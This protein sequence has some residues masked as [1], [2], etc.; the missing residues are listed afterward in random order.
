MP[1]RCLLLRQLG[2]GNTVT[3]NKGFSPGKRTSTSA[4]SVGLWRSTPKQR[5]RRSARIAFPS[6]GKSF[7][8][9]SRPKGHAPLATWTSCFPYSKTK[10]QQKKSCRA[11]VDARLLTSFE[12]TAGEEE[13]KGQH[14]VEIIHESLLKAWP[15][16]VRW[17]TQDEEGAQLRDELR[18][19][20]QLW[21]QHGR[22]ADR[23]W[24]GTP[25]KEFQLWRERY[26]GGLTNTEQDF[27][28]A[29]VQQA[30]RRRKRKRFAIA[31]TIGA[32]V[33]VVALVSAFLATE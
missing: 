29:M 13:E 12:V 6:Y 17:Q 30:E 23:L 32:L 11:L 9:W 24:T 31:A 7:A 28:Q 2:C 10:A 4:V 26:S 5:S 16:L 3:G 19:A 8:I 15:R 1:C 20:A 27:A 21:E 22:S 33:G 25:V 14:R 18:Q